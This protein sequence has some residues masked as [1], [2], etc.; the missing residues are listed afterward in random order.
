MLLQILA[1]LILPECD[2]AHPVQC[3]HEGELRAKAAEFNELGRSTA[4]DCEPHTHGIGVELPAVEL[5]SVVDSYAVQFW[6]QGNLKDVARVH[7]LSDLYHKLGRWESVLRK[8]SSALRHIISE[9]A[10]G[11]TVLSTRL[12]AVQSVVAAFEELALEMFTR[13][14]ETSY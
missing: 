7:C 5:P 2:T 11:T 12:R 10:V 4:A 14:K 6:E 3:E 9:E 8:I 1:F 13:Y